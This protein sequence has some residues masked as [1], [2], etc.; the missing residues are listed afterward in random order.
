[1]SA[2]ALTTLTIQLLMRDGY[3]APVLVAPDGTAVRPLTVD[4]LKTNEK[5]RVELRDFAGLQMWAQLT[6]HPA[7]H[8]YIPPVALPL[9]EYLF[10][11]QDQWWPRSKA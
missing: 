4:D 3:P 11:L 9:R 10:A 8:P 5:P 1:M 2:P 7:T 6:S